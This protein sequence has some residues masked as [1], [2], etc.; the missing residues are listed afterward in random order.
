ME[1]WDWE[2]WDEKNAD[3]RVRVDR[4]CQRMLSFSLKFKI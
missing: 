1:L 4:V 3:E 2:V